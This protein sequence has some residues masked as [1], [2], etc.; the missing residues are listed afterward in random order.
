MVAMIRP[1]VLIINDHPTHQMLASMMCQR[2]GVNPVVVDNP[3]DAVREFE[4]NPNYAA[5]IID[6]GLPED[7][8]ARECLHDLICARRKRR[9]HVP[10]IALTAHA[11]DS[12]RIK[13]LQ[14][15][16]D[17]YL[18]KPYTSQQF[19]QLLRR[20]IGDEADNRTRRAS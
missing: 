14:Q 11:M 5:V 17:D 2:H 16:A 6:L 20:W 15:G 10:M 12:D 1:R 7:P 9:V 3:R 13:C 8:D 18:S 4:R 19:G